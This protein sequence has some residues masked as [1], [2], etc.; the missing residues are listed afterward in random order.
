MEVNSE[1][2]PLVKGLIFRNSV[3]YKIPGSGPPH[4]AAEGPSKPPVTAFEGGHGNGRGQFDSPQGIAIDSAGNIFVAD[5]GNGRIQKFSPSGA[6]V[7][8]IGT[9]WSAEW[10]R[11]RSLG[12]H[13][14]RGDRLQCTAFRNSDLT[15]LSSLS[16][17]LDF[18][19]RAG[20]PLALIDSI[21]VVD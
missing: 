12:Q 10:A 4:L 18:T 14:R 1:K 7:T 2:E 5:T 15:G 6:F 9:I 19:G 21:Y 3:I 20:S 16:G 8:S 11:N 17:H 13:L